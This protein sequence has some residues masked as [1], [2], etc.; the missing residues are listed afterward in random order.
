MNHKQLLSAFKEEFERRKFVAGL[1][2]AFIRFFRKLDALGQK[3]PSLDDFF[4][5]FP[6]LATTSQGQTAN[7]LIVLLPSSGAKQKTLS[8]R[9]FYNEAER[10]FRAENKR[11]DYPNCAPHATQAW[12]DYRAWLDALLR[13]T[14]PQAEALEQ[15]V[16][17]FVLSKLPSHEFTGEGLEPLEQRFARLLQEFSFIAF[18]G[19]PAGSA[20]QG[21]VYAYI[22]ADAPHL[23][24]DV[25]KVGA[26]S[27]RLHRVGDI[28]G[29]EGERLVLSAEVKHFDMK[30]HDISD[31][32]AFANQVSA[33]KAMGIVV[34]LSFG[35]DARNDLEGMG[36][37][38]LAIDE[39]ARVVELWDPLKQRAAVA[40]FTYYSHHIE[41]SSVLMQRLKLFLDQ[42]AK[43][44]SS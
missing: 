19:E 27:K 28:D 30:R 11:F 36:L 26:G 8:I 41:K 25:S 16:S 3:Y 15:A 40:A 44:S 7:T 43:P 42:L 33:R 39:L 24:L 23:H 21:V 12:H 10:F 38:T 29:W 18:K 5:A 34:A 1:L 22:R 2:I 20:F 31:L 37:R 6:Q 17:E 9:P 32:S 35:D 13:L 14:T 4:Q